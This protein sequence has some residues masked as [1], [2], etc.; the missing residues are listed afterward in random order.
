MCRRPRGLACPAPVLQTK[1]AIEKEHPTV[2]K[3]VVGNDCMGHGDDELGE[4]LI[5]SFLEKL[6]EMGD[7]L[8]RLVFVN[9]GVKLSIEGSEVFPVIQEL[10][11]EGIQILVCGTCLT[12][13]DLLD[14]K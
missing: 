9:T 4:K 11:K 1:E 7:E 14:Q 13:F 2:I 3:V 5:L 8:W 12:H 10:E 6:K